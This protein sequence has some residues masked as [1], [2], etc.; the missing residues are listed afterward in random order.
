MTNKENINVV[1]KLNS[2]I[3][4][5]S[6]VKIFIFLYKSKTVADKIVGIARINE[7]STA[8]FLFSPDISEPTIVEPDLDTPGII[9]NI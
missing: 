6:R 2:I 4:K 8:V 5:L 7:N 1:K 9:D 3:F